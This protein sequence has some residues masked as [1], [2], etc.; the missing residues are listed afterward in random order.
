MAR[1]D[2]CREELVSTD[3]VRMQITVPAGEDEIEVTV[4]DSL[5]VVDVNDR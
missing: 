3:P 5:T 2:A 1:G 4:D